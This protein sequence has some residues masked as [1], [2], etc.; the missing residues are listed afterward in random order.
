DHVQAHGTDAGHGL[1]LVQAE[2]PCLCGGDH[3]LVLADGD[4]GAGEA[5][6]RG[7]RHDAA[8]LHR[9]VQQGQRRRSAVGAADLQAHLLQNAGHAVSD[10]RSRRQGE[11][12]DA[13][14]R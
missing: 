1:Q 2:G 6:H 3:A 8:L 12:H 5:A 11:I 9:V 10:G 14:G 13:E 4:E 7:G